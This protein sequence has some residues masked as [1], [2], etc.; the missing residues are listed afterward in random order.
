MTAIVLPEI[1]TGRFEGEIT[2]GGDCSSCR[3]CLR[4]CPAATEEGFL[5]ARIAGS[6]CVDCGACITVC[7]RQAIGYQDDTALFFEE[8]RKGTPI[9][10]LAAPAVYSQFA[11]A[12]QLLGFLKSLGVRSVYNVLLYADITIWAYAAVLRR[13]SGHGFIAS[14]CAAVSGYI[15]NHMPALR[16]HLMPVHSPLLCAAIYLKKYRRVQERLAFLS[17][18][19]AKRAEM[20]A[21]GRSSPDY[22]VTIG[23]LK[24]YLQDRGV[25]ITACRAAEA[26]DAA[27]GGGRTLGFYGGL[28]ESLAP[29]VARGCFVKISGTG[30]VYDYLAEYEKTVRRGGRLPEL[31]EAYNCAAGCDGGTGV[32]PAEAA[33]AVRNPE[34]CPAGTAAADNR[35]AV[36]KLFRRFGRELNMADFMR[37]Y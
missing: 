20:R 12:P 36:G 10:L 21:A 19:I 11:A 16:R 17:P 7:P 31:V 14:P 30:K 32:G 23:R 35:K 25:D 34:Q 26:D 1:S 9:S 13:N 3:Q 24:E 18:C 5:P 6:G 2:V 4:A 33:A 22:N 8:L 37:H 27:A 28:R 15:H 29:H